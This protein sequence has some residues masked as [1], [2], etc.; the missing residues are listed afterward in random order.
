MNRRWVSVIVVVAVIACL[1]F[2]VWANSLSPEL[3]PT[4]TLEWSRARILGY[5]S[6]SR[7]ADISPAP[8]G[9]VYLIW[10]TPANELQLVRVD[11]TGEILLDRALVVGAVKARDPQLHVDSAGSLHLVWRDE[12]PPHTIHYTRLTPEA[13]PAFPPVVLSTSARPTIAPPQLT[14]DDTGRAHVF[15]ADDTG[16]LHAVV[17]DEGELVQDFTLIIPDGGE[18]SLR[19]DEAGQFHLAWWQRVGANG[20][21]IFYATY[22][23]AAEVWSETQ[24]LEVLFLRVGQRLEG[25]TMGLSEERGYAFWSIVDRRAV[26]S[27]SEYATFPLESPSQAQVE[28]LDVQRGW[29][30]NNV[31][32]LEEQFATLWIAMSETVPGVEPALFLEALFSQS[33][34]IPSSQITLITLPTQGGIEQV[35]TAANQALVKPVLRVNEEGY[36]HLVALQVAGADLYRVVY[37]ST[38]PGVR[39]AY[40]A[41]TVFDAVNAFFTGLIQIS[42]FVLTVIPMLFLWTVLPAMALILYHWFSGAEELDTL[43]SRI[44]LGG[45]IALQILLTVVV[46]LSVELRWPIMRWIAPF[47]TAALAGGLT[48]LLLRKREENLLFLSYFAFAILQVMLLW[49]VYFLL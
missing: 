9:G 4:A 33:T 26:T 38:A 30:T 42:L 12:G 5:T 41:V 6:I 16:I 24:E 49:I 45:V 20:N 47:V 7:P 11:N 19:V 34:D 22:D 36:L 21:G 17:G 23:P 10:S 32:P 1:G 43:Q 48:W 29:D 8:D 37:A 2:L 31:A 27:W 14:L 46:P 3:I 40:N 13:R 35:V 25:P 18:P 39:Q 28:A 44:A 15:W